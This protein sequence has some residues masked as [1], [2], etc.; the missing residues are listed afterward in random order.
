MKTGYLV[1]C[2]VGALVGGWAGAGYAAGAGS[3]TT[4]AVATASSGAGVEEVVVTSV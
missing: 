2:A 1:S 4:S 3:E